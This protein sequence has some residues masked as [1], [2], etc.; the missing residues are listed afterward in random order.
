MRTHLRLSAIALFSLL[1]SCSDQAKDPFAPVEPTPMSEEEVAAAIKE[2]RDQNNEQADK[3]ISL[4]AQVRQLSSTVD[5]I[6]R[7]TSE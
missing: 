2:L 7:R 1:A 3:I 4:E 5:D 6:D